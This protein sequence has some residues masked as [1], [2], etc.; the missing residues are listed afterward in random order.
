MEVHFHFETILIFLTVAYSWEF[1]MPVMPTIQMV[2]SMKKVPAIRMISPMPVIQ[3]MPMI[4]VMPIMLPMLDWIIPEPDPNS[5]SFSQFSSQSLSQN[6]NKGVC[7]GKS[8]VMV[9]S[10]TCDNGKCVTE[11]Y[12][13][14]HQL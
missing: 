13:D 2:P 6:C 9:G 14:S 12:Q 4:P 1:Q 7:T 5:K 11:K 8:N 10:A 3:P